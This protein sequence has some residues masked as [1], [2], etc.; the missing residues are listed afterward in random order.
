MQLRMFLM[1]V[2]MGL[3]C[4]PC[5]DNRKIVTGS[6]HKLQSY[7]ETLL[8]ESARNGHCRQPANI[9]NAT[10]WVGKDETGLEIQRQRRRW[11]RLCGPSRARQKV[12]NK[13][14]IFF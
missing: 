11:N 9:A 13:K 8:S 12:S 4:S 10:E 6:A 3:K 7:R 1:P 14:S 2:G 5:L